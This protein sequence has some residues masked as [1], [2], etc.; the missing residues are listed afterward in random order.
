MMTPNPGRGLL[1]RLLFALALCSAA[2][3]HAG[4][5][6]QNV[7]IGGFSKVHI[8]TPTAIPRSAKASRC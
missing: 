4:S 6:Q 1:R 2:A 8:Y 3:G 5:W 7:A